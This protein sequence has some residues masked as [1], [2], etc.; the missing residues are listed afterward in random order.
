VT[1]CHSVHRVEY[2]LHLIFGLAIY[3]L[4]GLQHQTDSV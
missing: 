2:N 4:S 1:L 3:V